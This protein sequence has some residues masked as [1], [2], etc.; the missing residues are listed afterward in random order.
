MGAPDRRPAKPL[1]VPA[2]QRPAVLTITRA[3]PDGS[4]DTYTWEIAA[5]GADVISALFG[6]PL[7]VG[8]YS[9]EH[10]AVAAAMHLGAP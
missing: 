10:T 5:S 7:D 4:A 2:D 3:N 6:L 1:P 8:H 9:A